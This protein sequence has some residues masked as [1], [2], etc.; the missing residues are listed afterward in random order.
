M[1]LNALKLGLIAS[2]IAFLV[3]PG[4][5]ARADAMD[6]CIQ[7]LTQPIVANRQAKPDKNLSPRVAY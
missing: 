7:E 1:N 2:C 3:P 6:E 5:E 4:H